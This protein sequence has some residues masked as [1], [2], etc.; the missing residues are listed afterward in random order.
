MNRAG[1]NAPGVF[2]H[3]AMSNLSSLLIKHSLFMSNCPFKKGKDTVGRHHILPSMVIVAILNSFPACLQTPHSYIL[4]I[5]IH[6]FSQQS[7]FLRQGF[8]LMLKFG[9]CKR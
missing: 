8:I 9:N 4:R 3:E 7:N 5:L 1:T 2:N 6:L